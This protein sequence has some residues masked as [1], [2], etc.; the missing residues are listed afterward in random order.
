[1][2]EKNLTK[3][4]RK[5]HEKLDPR[6]KKV[7][8]DILIY[9]RVNTSSE[10]H[11]TEAALNTLL[12]KIIQTQREGGSI[13]SVT[14]ENYRAYA[15]SL[16]EKLP[17]RNI[18]RLASFLA[19]ILV[20]LN[21]IFDYLIQIFFRLIDSAALS[22]TL[23][24]IQFTL[25]MIIT[26]ALVIGFIYA[27]FHTFRQIAFKAWPAWKEYGLYFLIGFGFFLLYMFLN[28]LLTSI[29]SGPSFEVNMFLIVL[30][31]IILLA[32]GILGFYRKK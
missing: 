11:E 19:L 32:L 25:E 29:D 28:I 20:G 26:A 22:T 17:Q 24:V 18:L 2:A 23:V 5:L 13:T 4:N 3:E 1:M 21:L 8:E 15:D 6:Y 27:I 14:G 16:I 10:S 7:Y 30:L 31:G 12:K 9:I